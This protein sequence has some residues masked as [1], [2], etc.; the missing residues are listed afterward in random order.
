M[1]FIDFDLFLG[2]LIKTP[3][4]LSNF[5]RF[6]HTPLLPYSELK[7]LPLAIVIALTIVLYL[8]SLRLLKGR[9]IHNS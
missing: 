4:W 6:T 7:V 9:D 2:E 1:F 8:A 5:S 3:Q